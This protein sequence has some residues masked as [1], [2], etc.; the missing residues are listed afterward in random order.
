MPSVMYNEC[1]K[2]ALYAERRYA[3]CH[4][5]QCHYARCH[6][7][8]CLG[9]LSTKPEKQNLSFISKVRNNFYLCII[10]YL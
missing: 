8:E 5:A 2:L 10:G 6:Y 1:H 7:A 3:E 4:Y 9:A